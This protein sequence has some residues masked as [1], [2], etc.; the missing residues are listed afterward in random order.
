MEQRATLGVA[1]LESRP[2]DPSLL[3]ELADSHA[4]LAPS[5]LPGGHPQSGSTQADRR[6]RTARALTAEVMFMIASTHEELGDRQQALQWLARSV[7]AGQAL[8]D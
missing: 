4:V 8:N 2:K 7:K 3:A 1:A 5:T 6:C